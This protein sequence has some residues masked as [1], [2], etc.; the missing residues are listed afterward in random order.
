LLYLLP[1]PQQWGPWHK[2]DFL[3]LICGATLGP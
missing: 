3:F 2:G 1:T